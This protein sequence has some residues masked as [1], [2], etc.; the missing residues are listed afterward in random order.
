MTGQAQGTP[1]PADQLKAEKNADTQ[2]PEATPPAKDESGHGEE[3]DSSAPAPSEEGQPDDKEELAK[4]REE[5][6][7]QQVQEE[8]KRAQQE[9]ERL[10]TIESR[11]TETPEK[12]KQALV[13]INGWPEEQ[14]SAYVEQLKVQGTWANAQATPPA[15]PGTAMPQAPQTT[16]PQAPQ[17]PQAQ[18]SKVDPVLAAQVMVQHEMAAQ[19][20]QQQF[21]EK[22]PE[23][24]PKNV[25]P[26]KHPGTKTFVSAVETEA[27]RR[28]EEKGDDK[29]DAGLL[30][31]LVEVYK[32]FT[33]K[34][35]K[36][37][38]KAREE[39]KLEGYLEANVEKSS[40]AKPPKGTSP[41]DESYGL[42]PE[43]M[44]QAKAEGLS[45]KEFA[46][47]KDP[48]SQVK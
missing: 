32:E 24:D 17:A 10:R 29:G 28:M 7:L 48:V 26:E 46:N 11:L 44:K 39:G 34:T 33:G 4:K 27:R 2:E 6:K 21:F 16:A 38:K 25:P 9:Q 36:E 14:A 15:Q 1:D 22:V 41:S 47:L 23:L 3:P 42:T 12:Y 45:P 19:R 37:L 5:G 40:K 8:L 43:E 13:D 30:D 20:L 35:D 18:T 31:E